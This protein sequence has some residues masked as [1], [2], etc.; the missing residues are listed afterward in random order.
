MTADV[1][2]A[3]SIALE[4]DKLAVAYGRTRVLDGITLA[5]PRGSVACSGNAHPPPAGR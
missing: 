4:T 2:V 5:V 3:A 1:G